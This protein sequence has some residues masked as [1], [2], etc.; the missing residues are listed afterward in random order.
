M[1]IPIPLLIKVKLPLGKKLILGGMFFVG[2]VTVRQ[3][4]D[5]SRRYANSA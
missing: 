4:V 5:G 2:S 1:A 3:I